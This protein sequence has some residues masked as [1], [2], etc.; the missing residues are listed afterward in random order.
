MAQSQAPNDRFGL[1]EAALRSV[2]S[3]RAHPYACDSISISCKRRFPCTG[4]VV[5]ATGGTEF[6]PMRRDYLEGEVGVLAIRSTSPV[7]LRVM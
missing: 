3:G 1:Q 5:A 2:P 7:L 4:G 6:D